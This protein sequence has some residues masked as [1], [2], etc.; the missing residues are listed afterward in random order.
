MTRRAW[1]RDF[2]VFASRWPQQRPSPSSLLLVRRKT[3]TIAFWRR[4]VAKCPQAS[5][6]TRRSEEE[7]QMMQVRVLC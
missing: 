7:R 3:A 6:A 5:F 1:Q 4:N 2:S